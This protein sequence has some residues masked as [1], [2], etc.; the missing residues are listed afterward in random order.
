VKNPSGSGAQGVDIRRART[1][2][3]YV[4]TFCDGSYLGLSAAYTTTEKRGLQAR[5]SDARPSQF[6][7]RF[8][9]RSGKPGASKPP[10][11]RGVGRGAP[12]MHAGQFATLRQVLEH[13]NRAPAA[14]VGRSELHPLHLGR[15]D[16]EALRAFLFD[17]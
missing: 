15:E 10:S 7:I 17:A 14:T 6:A 2:C 1:T 11:L 12:Y 4:R 16:L 8:L 3:Q 5:F 9:V 13:Y